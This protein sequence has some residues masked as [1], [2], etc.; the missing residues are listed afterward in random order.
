MGTQNSLH[1]VF[2]LGR[3]LCCVAALACAGWAQSDSLD[4]AHVVP[5]NQPDPVTRASAVPASGLNL[6]MRPLRVDVNLVLVPV[7]VTDALSRP[8]L[9][10]PAQE[11][12]IYEAG[13]EQRIGYF[14]AEDSPI[15]VAIVVDLSASMKNKVEYEAQALEEFL[16]NANPQ[17]DYFV[18]AISSKPRV[19]ASSEDSVGTIHDRLTLTPPAGG[20]ALFDAAYL[21]VAKLRTSRYKRKAM[22][23][24]SDG[25]DNRSRYTLKE[26]KSVIEEADVLTYGIGIFDDMP[27][28]LLKTIEERAGTEVAQRHYRSQRRPHHRRRR[29]QKDPRHCCQGEP[30]TAQSV[31]H[32]IQPQ[33]SRARRQVPEDHGAIGPVGNAAPCALQGRVHRTRTVAVRGAGFRLKQRNAGFT[34]KPYVQ[35]LRSGGVAARDVAFELLDVVFLAGDDPLHQVAD[36]QHASD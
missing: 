33:Q 19:I 36:G 12:S 29:P 23:I 20:T 17:D 30:R 27:I 15:S 22:V 4:Q 18:V 31:C 7:T 11:F 25:G 1:P 35:Q 13:V 6:A 28:P 14:S 34:V 5:R 3:V 8:I 26:I 2:S 21:G 24:I 9:D 16:K 10:L 32:R